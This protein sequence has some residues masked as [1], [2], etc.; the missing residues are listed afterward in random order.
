[1]SILGPGS[2][3]ALGLAAAAAAAQQRA[4]G[5]ADRDKAD[6]AQQK[7]EADQVRLANRDLDDR[8]R[9]ISRTARFPTAIRTVDF[10][11]SAQMEVQ[12]VT[13]SRTK[14]RRNHA[15]AVPRA[16]AG[17]HWMSM[18]ERRLEAVAR[19]GTDVPRT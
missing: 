8:V 2:L 3:P 14:Q 9:P 12:R 13:R 19:T 15:L 17:G 5:L 7:M 4:A 16:N 10:R 11:G 18:S 6:Q 1:M